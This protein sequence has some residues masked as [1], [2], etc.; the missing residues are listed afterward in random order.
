MIELIKH[1]DKTL[2]PWLALSRF[3][4]FWI[5]TL[6]HSLLF[7]PWQLLK[8]TC[9]SVTARLSPIGSWFHW[10]AYAVVV[11]L[12]FVIPAP[13]FANDKEGLALIV[14]GAVGLRVA[15]TLMGG[16][17]KFSPCAVDLLVLAFLGINIIAT[18][19]SHY[20][21]A[22]AKGLA[23][24]AVYISSYFLFV[25]V[26]Q[27]DTKKRSLVV[28]SSLLLSG[29]LISLYGVYQYKIGVAP[30]AT[31]EDPSI[32]DKT[33]RVY[34]TLRNPNL[35][36]GYLVPLIPL[37]LG[38]AVMV[39]TSAKKWWRACCL[40]PL[41]MGAVTILSC[42]FTGSRGGYIGIAAGLAELALICLVTLWVNFPKQRVWLVALLVGTPVLLALGLHQF[43]TYE[44]RVLSM[45]AGRD[46]S[47]NSYRL[48]VY[49]SSFR[50]F[51]DN[52][53]IGVG[54]GNQAFRLCYGLYMHT[55]FDALGTYCVPL[56]VA[57][58]SG[59][60]GLGVFVATIV[61]L[62]ARAHQT[63]WASR[64]KSERWILAAT[65]S[66][67]VAMMCH[68]L[69][70][71]V[72]YRPQVQLI[73]WLLAAIMVTVGRNGG[74]TTASQPDAGFTQAAVVPAPAEI[75]SEQLP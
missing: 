41:G 45:F 43:P 12:F 75:G 66:A 69:V 26:L 56:E 13:P 6:N 2:V 50:M 47:S 30:L 44:H 33:T 11:V 57:V 7:R 71:T 60:A 65:A 68:G 49:I 70:D 36:A 58:E 67:M 59:I 48:N 20:F 73:F 32:E 54:P 18:A 64:G 40:I 1:L 61:A 42:I 16:K 63:F 22:S 34:A 15:G 38:M 31:W 25:S 53:W 27:T 19:G 10:L 55:G 46:H 62:M 9:L 17:E 29:L 72:F 3:D 14:L 21:A 28:L 51:L 74:S 37:A 5:E 24:L 8:A 39:G 4:Q 52:W 23:K 35:L